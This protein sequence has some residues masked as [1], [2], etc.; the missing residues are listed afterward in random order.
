ML[1]AKFG[2]DSSTEVEAMNKE[3][4]ARFQL[5]ADYEWIV[6]I[7]GDPWAQVWRS[8]VV[9]FLGPGHIFYLLF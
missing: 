5:K 2:N 9:G 6:Y 8:G 1:S 3:N 7:V 4:F